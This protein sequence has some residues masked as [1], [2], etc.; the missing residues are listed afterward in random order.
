MAL[1]L[2]KLSRRGISP[3]GTSDQ[4]PSVEVAFCERNC[5]YVAGQRM[6]VQWRS[7]S[8]LGA[9][10]CG[11]EAS[12]LWFTEGKGETDL[13]VH[14]FNHWTANELAKINTTEWNG[15]S[16]YLPYYPLSYAGNLLRIRWCCRVRLLCDDGVDRFMEKTFLLSSRTDMLD[17]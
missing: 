5:R 4:A 12:I 8:P 2:P 13:Q 17:C 1:V 16:C 11:L 7:S 3:P 9:F 6:S 10:I 15:F 14:A